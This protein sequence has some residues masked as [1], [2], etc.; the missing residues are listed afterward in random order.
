MRNGDLHN[1][2][3]NLLNHALDNRPAMTTN[4]AA[5][6]NCVASK[7]NQL[8]DSAAPEDQS[9][10]LSL[11]VGFGSLENG[12]RMM[13]GTELYH[14]PHPPIGMQPKDTAHCS[15]GSTI[16]DSNHREGKCHAFRR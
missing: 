4:T 2:I 7:N 11:T 13:Q 16:P 14:P 5:C 6:R 3:S 10:D 8:R 12:R 9:S 15:V 1:E